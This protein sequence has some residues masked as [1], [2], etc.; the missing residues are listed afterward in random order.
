MRIIINISDQ[1]QAEAFLIW[2][3]NRGD[4]LLGNMS[5]AEDFLNT[6]PDSGH[7]E[8]AN[9]YIVDAVEMSELRDDKS[10]NHSGNSK[11]G[12]AVSYSKPGPY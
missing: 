2:V 1:K 11:I 12:R 8:P 7:F 9:V 5:D 3:Q 4:I 10:G 6:G